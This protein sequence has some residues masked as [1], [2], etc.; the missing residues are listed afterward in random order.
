MNYFKE[1]SLLDNALAESV[2]ALLV[3]AINE[4]GKATLAVSGGSTP[5]N[6]FRI[7]SNMDLPWDKVA[8]TLADERWVSPT[9]DD[10]NTRLV[11]EQLLQNKA[12]KAH[13]FEL[14]PEKPLFTENSTNSLNETSTLDKHLETLNKSATLTVLPFDVLILGM[15][16]D[17]HTASLFP[18]SAQIKAALA[19][20]NAEALMTVSPT[21]AAYKRITFTLASLLKSEHIFI[22]TVGKKKGQV[23][24]KA[25]SAGDPFAMPIRAFLHHPNVATQ[26]Y[27]TD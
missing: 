15:G 23:I 12:A 16:E 7:L 4:K 13:F 18:C 10:S 19:I 9:S 5:K 25:L 22:H 3:K 8:I 14:L 26:L 11:K 6:F 17:G 1:T 24:E 21:T 20:D 27:F 2:S